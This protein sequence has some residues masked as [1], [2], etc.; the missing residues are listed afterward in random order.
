[1]HVAVLPELE[2]FERMRAEEV[3]EIGGDGRCRLLDPGAGAQKQPLCEQI[4]L[5]HGHRGL[6][7]AEGPGPI[8]LA[9]RG[10]R[11]EHLQEAGR[12]HRLLRKDDK[13]LPGIGI[14]RPEQR[15][16]PG[17]Q[18][19]AERVRRVGRRRG[20]SKRDQRIVDG[21]RLLQHLQRGRLGVGSGRGRA[22]FGRSRVD[23][24]P[25]GGAA[26]RNRRCWRQDFCL[27][28]NLRCARGSRPR[29]DC[30]DATGK[31]SGIDR[32][33]VA[34]LRRGQRQSLTRGSRTRRVIAFS[35]SRRN[36]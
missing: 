2:A 22:L 19:A 24:K 32:S 28:G 31:A 34:R 4:A 27:I 20:I 17:E 25:R 36:H 12:L 26:R 6:G 30:A 23:G 35:E 18:T 10:D 9:R 29:F 8:L 21:L 1:V 16:H 11:S 33:V 3:G 7:V 14:F 13:A 5:A 15:V